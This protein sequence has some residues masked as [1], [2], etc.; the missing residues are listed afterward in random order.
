MF[1]YVNSKFPV[2]GAAACSGLEG[3]NAGA[4]CMKF[5]PRGKTIYLDSFQAVFEAVYSG[6]CEYG[7]LPIEN[8]FNGSVRAVYDL[9]IQYKFSIVRSLLLPIRHFLLAKH[10]V[11]IESIKTIYSHSQA[12]GQCSKFLNDLAEKYKTQSLPFWNTAGAAK[13]VSENED[14]TLAAIASP[15]CAEL[16]GLDSIACDIQNNNNNYTKFICISKTPAIYDRAD[17]ISLIVTCENRPGALNKILSKI[18]EHNVNMNKL[19]SCPKADG[20]F[21]Y[22]FFLELEASLKN[23]GIISMLD[24]IEKNCSECVFLGNYALV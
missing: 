7:V 16:Y 20:Q 8:S 5:F 13:M 18:F 15:L 14:T 10:G 23:S 17:H 4:A 9:L 22:L 3:S 12:L 19:E 11:R 6:R 1:N 2:D 24:D 21:E